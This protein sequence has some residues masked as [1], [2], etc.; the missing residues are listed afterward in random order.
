MDS[1][2]KSSRPGTT[3]KILWYNLFLYQKCESK[4]SNEI[5]IQNILKHNFYGN[6]TSFAL[7]NKNKSEK[8][9]KY[10]SLK[11]LAR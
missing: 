4:S 9:K 10:E 2:N 11:M 7:Y 8:F 6:Q 3:G 5:K 1:T